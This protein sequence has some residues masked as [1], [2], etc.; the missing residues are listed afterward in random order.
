MIRRHLRRPLRENKLEFTYDNLDKI[1]K[2]LDATK[3]REVVD[4]VLDTLNQ[5]FNT[6]NFERSYIS[7]D[8]ADWF[9]KRIK[10]EKIRIEKKLYD[11]MISWDV[12]IPNP[13]S[14]FDE[15]VAEQAVDDLNDKLA[16]TGTEVELAGR[17]NG[18]LVVS[19]GH[20]IFQINSFYAKKPVEVFSKMFD[21]IALAYDNETY[22]EHLVSEYRDIYAMVESLICSA[23]GDDYEYYSSSGGILDVA[24]SLP[25]ELSDNFIKDLKFIDIEVK[26]FLNR[27]SE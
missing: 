11:G 26:K 5:T 21:F 15:E 12:K 16:K 23:I 19:R 27:Y 10:S 13:T 6:D 20:D 22:F 1:L 2:N 4:E 24:L 14:N 8:T 3:C 7:E 9:I 25:F 18:H 17:S